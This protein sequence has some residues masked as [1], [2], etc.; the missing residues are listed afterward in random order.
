[1]SKKKTHE[2]FLAQFEQIEVKNRIKILGKYINSKTKITCQCLKNSEHIF[3]KLP[4]HILN[5]QGCPF[6]AKYSGFINKNFTEQDFDKKLKQI[7][8]TIKRVSSYK[9]MKTKMEFYCT[10]C[11]HN[12]K[13]L[14]EV[15]LRGTACPLCKDCISFNNRLLRI[16]LSELKVDNFDYEISFEW[17]E[18][19][20]YDAYFTKNE[21]GKKQEYVIEAQ[22][23][24]HYRD[25]CFKGTKKKI[26]LKNTQNNDYKKYEL[27]ISHGLKVIYLN[28]NTNN[29]D[30]VFLEYIEVLQRYFD[31]STINLQKCLQK[32]EKV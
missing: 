16:M 20:R 10:D 29:H 28:C 15:V 27:A 4:N 1:M 19:K 2:E 23:Q 30:E 5:N 3:E 18:G 6:C 31:L 25:A 22:G 11:G 13:R 8:P 21:D 7:N 26:L 32:A 17:S 14:P 12:F 24:Q 9:N